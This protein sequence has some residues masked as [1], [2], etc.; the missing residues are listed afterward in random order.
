MPKI[1]IQNKTNLKQRVLTLMNG[2]KETTEL[3]FNFKY[4]GSILGPGVM[5]INEEGFY[6]IDIDIL[7]STNL[8]AQETYSKIIEGLKPHIRSIEHRVSKLN[9][10]ICIKVDESGYKYKMDIAI[11]NLYGGKEQKMQKE[12]QTYV[13]SK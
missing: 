3:S 5:K 9:A 11:F 13:W 2:L 10:V 7:V 12:K 4:T 1:S 8:N 6:D